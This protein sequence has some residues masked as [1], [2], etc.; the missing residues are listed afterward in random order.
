MSRCILIENEN[1]PWKVLNLRSPRDTDFNS[2]NLF[3]ISSLAG[4]EPMQTD[5]NSVVLTA[6]LR[7]V[8]FNYNEPI[9]K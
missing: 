3:T 4:F 8:G 7:A 6:W 2:G 9:Q 5:L 1:Y